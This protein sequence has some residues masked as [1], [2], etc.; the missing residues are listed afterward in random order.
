MQHRLV[1]RVAAAVFLL[2]LIAILAFATLVRPANDTHAIAPAALAQRATDGANLYQRHCESC[3]GL[4]DMLIE[5]RA[6]DRIHDNAQSMLQL[7]RRHG[8]ATDEEDW[9]IVAWLVTRAHHGAQ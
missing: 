5:L 4:D 9:Q 8:K 7:L 2:C 3:H 1:V 6:G